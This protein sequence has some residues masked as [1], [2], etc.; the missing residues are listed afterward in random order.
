MGTNDNNE[1]LKNLQGQLMNAI[2]VKLESDMDGLGDQMDE[3]KSELSVVKDIQNSNKSELDTKLLDIKQQIDNRIDSL[4]AKIG[5]KLDTFDV[6]FRGNGR[7]GLF[8]QIRGITIK[9]RVLFAALL[10]LLGAKALGLDFN[11]WMSGLFGAEIKKVE[12]TND[13]WP[14]E[15]KIV[16]ETEN[17]NER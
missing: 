14:A 9:I 2:Q 13:A 4:D 15:P 16:G 6:A 12:K 7:I 1:N 10:L 5:H 8:E 3:V 17:E 11:G